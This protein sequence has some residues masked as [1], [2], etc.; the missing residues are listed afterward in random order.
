MSGNRG[1]PP[2]NGEV[3]RHT[4]IVIETYDQGVCDIRM[5][6]LGDTLFEGIEQSATSTWLWLPFVG[7]RV[8][9]EER[10][11]PDAQDQPEIVG[12]EFDVFA[13]HPA[14]RENVSVG[15]SPDGNVVIV[16][17]GGT[18]TIEDG[19]DV[20]PALFLGRDEATEP[21]VLGLKQKDFL[22]SFLDDVETL[23]T[24]TQTMLLSLKV[25]ATSLAVA[26]DPVVV[27]AAAALTSSLAPLDLSSL[28]FAGKKGTIDDH[29]STLVFVA[30]E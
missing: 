11:S 21:A 6:G 2:K 19:G 5:E 24:T 26:V 17:D 25:F 27:A 14:R 9:V 1:R 30:E 16:L 4:G 29:H 12:L 28:D 10:P 7:Q 13:A 20:D 22:E 15:A 3:R 8:V 23:S 18:A